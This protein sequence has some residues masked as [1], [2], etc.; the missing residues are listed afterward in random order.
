VEGADALVWHKHIPLEVSIFAWRLVKNT[1]PTR[2]NLV[3]R[4]ILSEAGAGYLCSCGDIETT[5]HLFISCD[6][7]GTL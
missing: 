4:G 7:Y 5:Q 6:F 3:H 1:L 2:A